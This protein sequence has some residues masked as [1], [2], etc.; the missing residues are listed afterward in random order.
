[1]YNNGKEER[2]SADAIEAG[3]NDIN[4]VSQKSEAMLFGENVQTYDGG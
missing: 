3:T 2:H 4:C 1:M